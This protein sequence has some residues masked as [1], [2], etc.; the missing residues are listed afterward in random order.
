[1][2]PSRPREG[3]LHRRLGLLPDGI[4]EGG[5]PGAAGGDDLRE[6]GRLRKRRAPNPALATAGEGT[7][8]RQGGSLAGPGVLQAL[9]AEGGLEG[10][11][12]A[13]ARRRRLRGGEA[14][15][16]TRPGQGDGLR[17]GADPLRGALRAA[18]DEEGEVAGSRGRR[19]PDTGSGVCAGRW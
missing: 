18:R 14:P 5:G 10:T 17:P 9:Q 12:P 2:D 15:R 11:V 19:A 13:R 6:V 4:G 1:V 16:R 8:G 7:R 3:Q